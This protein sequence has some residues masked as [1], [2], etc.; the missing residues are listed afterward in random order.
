[1]RVT[2]KILF[3]VLILGFLGTVFSFAQEGENTNQVL[4]H[5]Q[6]QD[7]IPIIKFKEADIRVVLQSIAEKATKD[8]QKVN[9]VASPNVT[10]LVDINLENVNWFT[11]LEAVLRSYNY[12]YEWVGTN[13]ILVDTVEAI[14][15]REAQQKARQEVEPARTKVFNLRYID[16]NDAKKAVEP[17]LSPVGRVS[18]LE[19]TGQAGWEFG[20]DVTKRARAQE[21]KVSRTKT[22]VVS[23][24][25]K[26]LDEIAVL[27]EEI[28]IKPMQILISARIMEVSTDLLEDI[29]FEWGTGANGASSASFTEFDKSN[30]KQALARMHTVT[31]SVFNPLEGD[32]LTPET[33]GL[34]LALKKITGNNFEAV[35]NALTEDARTNT[36]SAPKILTLNNQ[37]AAILV[38]T[39]YP[40]IET[41]VSTETSQ[42]TGGS[43]DYYQ[44]IGIQLNVVP[45]ISGE[46]SEF[47]SMIIHPAV[48]AQSGSVE[49]KASATD[50]PII[51]YPIITSREAETQVMVADGETIVIGGLIKDVKANEEIG[52]PILKDIPLIGWLFKRTTEDIE[53]IDL[54]IFLTAKIVEPGQIIPEEFIGTEEFTAK[55]N[56][57][58]KK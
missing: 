31:P 12:S 8:G 18:V 11:A 45:Q 35:L 27:V 51:T 54:L 15:E 1:M 57:N 24:I 13:I 32:L 33:A 56:D 58:Q 4:P 3:L 49:V 40:I 53:K 28:D 25:S 55:Y 14:S 36:L 21:G 26:R 37:E 23:D 47:I 6:Y 10:G 46:N 5:A 50:T 29:G 42:I 52:V 17:L 43:L 2:K 22:L 44:D 7:I 48:T 39:K 30:N 16:A 9:I 41:E 20:T 19:V 34:K 38:G